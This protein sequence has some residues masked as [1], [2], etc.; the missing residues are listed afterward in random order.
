MPKMLEEN[1]LVAAAGIS[2]APLGRRVAGHVGHVPRRGFLSFVL[3]IRCSIDAERR[4]PAA[5]P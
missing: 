2:P 3:E 1:L 4:P 5:D